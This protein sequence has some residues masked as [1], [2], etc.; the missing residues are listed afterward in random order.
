MTALPGPFPVTVPFSTVATSWLEE[1]QETPALPPE[2]DSA[3][4]S[5]A[6]R[7]RAVWDRVRGSAGSG[8]L[9]SGV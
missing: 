8:S 5:P 7:D 4:L 9:F 6:T 2:A 1:V 3:A